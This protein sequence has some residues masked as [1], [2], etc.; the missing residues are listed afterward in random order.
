MVRLQLWKYLFVTCSP[1]GYSQKNWLGVCGLLPKTLTLFMTQICD[2]PI[3]DL[4][5]NLKPYNLTLKSKPCFRP[6]L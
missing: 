6:A 5:K 4:T 2:Y 1:V 3:Y